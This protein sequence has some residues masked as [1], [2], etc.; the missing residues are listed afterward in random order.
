MEIELKI[1]RESL[2]KLTWKD[3]CIIEDSQGASYKDLMRII[4]KFVTGEDGQPMEPAQAA[5]I[6][7]DLTT[8]EMK[9]TFQNFG[10]AITKA[11]KEMIPNE[12]GGD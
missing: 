5:N 12:S 11:T 4:S 7:G 6:L 8:T 3:W 10:K 1:T 9:L 2:D